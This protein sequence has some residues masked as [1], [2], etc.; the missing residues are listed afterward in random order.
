VIFE[1]CHI[2]VSRR[3][4][5]VG[6]GVVCLIGDCY[7]VGGGKEGERRLRSTCDLCG[8]GTFGQVC[9][10]WLGKWGVESARS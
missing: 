7:Q 10:Q 5:P 9:Q 2:L 1:C 6:R 8:Q 3:G 4:M